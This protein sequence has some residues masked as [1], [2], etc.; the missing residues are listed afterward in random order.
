[1]K[2]TMTFHLPPSECLKSKTQV[3][4]YPGEDMQQ[5]EHASIDDVS[6]NLYSHFGN[7]HGGFSEN[8]K[9]IYIKTQL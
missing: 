9:S 7:E 4:A 8:W 2:M 1:M 6:A 5:G 3:V